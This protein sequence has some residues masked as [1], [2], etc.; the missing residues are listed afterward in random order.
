MTTKKQRDIE[1]VGKLAQMLAGVA[2]H[3]ESTAVGAAVLA[4]MAANNTLPEQW[5]DMLNTPLG[6]AAAGV[7]ML[8]R[9]KK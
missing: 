4:F 1:E 2:G 9:G 3:K 6:L 8:Y 5:M 7:L